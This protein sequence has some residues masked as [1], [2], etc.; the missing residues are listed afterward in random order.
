MNEAAYFSFIDLL[1]DIVNQINQNEKDI[2]I[3]KK[4]INE[5]QQKNNNNCDIKD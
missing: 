1:K 2:N 3:L 4:Q 5:L